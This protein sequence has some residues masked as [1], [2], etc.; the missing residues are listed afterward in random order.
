MPTNNLISFQAWNSSLRDHVAQSRPHRS[1]QEVR[2]PKEASCTIYNVHTRYVYKYI[3][4]HVYLHP[5][6]LGM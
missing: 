1:L 2:G 6:I 5:N 3:V 4:S